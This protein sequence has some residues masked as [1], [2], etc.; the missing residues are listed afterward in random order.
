MTKRIRY[1][2]FIVCLVYGV[3]VV[4]YFR[5][6]TADPPPFIFH[7]SCNG[8]I[9]ERADG[10]DR[11]RISDDSLPEDCRSLEE[12]TWSPTGRWFKAVAR[13]EDAPDHSSRDYQRH[14]VTAF[15]YDGTQRLTVFDHLDWV[16]CAEWSPKDDYLMLTR[17]EEPPIRGE[18]PLGLYV[19]DANSGRIEFKTTIPQ[20]CGQWSPDG[21]TVYFTDEESNPFLLTLADWK[22]E[23][24]SSLIVEWST[25]SRLVYFDR[26][27]EMLRIGNPEGHIV[28]ENQWPGGFGHYWDWSPGGD[29]VLFFTLSEGLRSSLDEPFKLWLLSLPD[30]SIQLISDRATTPAPCLYATCVIELPVTLWTPT[31][32]RAVFPTVDGAL[33]WFD[34]ADRRIADTGLPIPSLV[35]DE[36]TIQ[37]VGGAFWLPHSP[38]WGVE[39][40]DYYGFFALEEGIHVYDLLA[41]RFLDE[42]FGWFLNFGVSSDGRFVALNGFCDVDLRE[43]G[44]HCIWDWQDGVARSVLPSDRPSVYS[45]YGQVVWHDT[46]TWVLLA[47]AQVFVRP[48]PMWSVANAEGTFHRD[49]TVLNRIGWLPDNVDTSH[50]PLSPPW[51]TRE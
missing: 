29:Y 10:S 1:I 2:L 27:T 22:L 8:L 43:S 11:F 51:K 41:D 17:F 9:I 37:Q 3:V 42:T 6:Q 15:R 28:F 34:L 46:E 24:S 44:G 14:V 26:D 5:A 33:M 21:S 7:Y 38:T 39:W 13:T 18:G 23:Q 49:L 47:D 35:M 19:I 25:E 20:S 30:Q 32:H 31:G 50:I 40:S 45:E 48:V 12:G 4:N 16:V 36:A